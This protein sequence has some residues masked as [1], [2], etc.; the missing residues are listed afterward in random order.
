MKLLLSLNIFLSLILLSGCSED[1]RTSEPE[2]KKLVVKLDPVTKP[3]DTKSY[4]F[5]AH[6]SAVKTIE[7]SFE[8]SGRLNRVDLPTGTRVQKGQL[9]ATL[10]PEPFKNAV[11]ERQAR[12]DQA[13]RTLNRISR[14]YER[15]LAPLNDLDNA[16][17]NF[18]VF[19]IELN[20]A[21]QDLGFTQLYSPFDAQ[22]S[23]RLVDNR[24][25][26]DAGAPIAR[27]QDVS[28]TYFRINVPERILSASLDKK[29]LTATAS[30]IADPERRFDLRYIEH[31]TQPDPVT[32]TYSVILAMDPVPG[33][34]ITPGARATVNVELSAG[35]DVND[36]HHKLPFSALIGDE[37]SGF[38]VWKYLPENHGVQAIPVKVISIQQGKVV[39]EADLKT[40]DKIVSAGAAKMFAGATVTEYTQEK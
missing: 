21:R 38:E 5:P 37:E 36:T 4:K 11:E 32:Q 24:N 9:L 39:V 22:I 40:G 19:E 23:E 30:L 10:D 7:L 28:Q 1:T 14:L 6:V 18:E 2:I 17:T 29:L 31:S 33:F 3:K 15:G 27:L 25:Y 13:E 8:V 20:R 16:R 34:T 12:R 26:V 35:N